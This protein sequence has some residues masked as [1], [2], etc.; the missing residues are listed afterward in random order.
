[1]NIDVD[2]LHRMAS[3]QTDLAE[4]WHEWAESGDTSDEIGLEDMKNYATQAI[5]AALAS[6]HLLAEYRNN[7]PI[8]ILGE[9]PL[10][11]DKD[12][13]LHYPDNEDADSLYGLLEKLEWLCDQAGYQA[14]AEHVTDILQHVRPPALLENPFER[15][16]GIHDFN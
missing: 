4:S 9:V 7:E 8:R 3:L 16:G 10:L 13:P 14:G 1:D 15:L 12:T 5:D 2:D 11:P 6:A